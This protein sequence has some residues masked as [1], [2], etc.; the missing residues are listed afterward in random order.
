M[1]EEADSSSFGSDE[2]EQF[3]LGRMLDLETEGGH[4]N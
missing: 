1:F 3:H 2:H 4:T